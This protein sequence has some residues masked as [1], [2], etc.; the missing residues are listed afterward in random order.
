[1]K[2]STKLPSL[3]C[4]LALQKVSLMIAIKQS[5]HFDILVAID[6]KDPLAIKVFED[7]GKVLAK[8]I[9]AFLPQI[10]RPF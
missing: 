4:A 5:N 2:N 8:H 7:A 9:L 6:K 10:V 3:N 1:M